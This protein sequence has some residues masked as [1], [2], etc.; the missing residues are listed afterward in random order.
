M[1]AL[2][3][4]QDELIAVTESNQPT[5]L[6]SVESRQTVMIIALHN[7]AV[8]YEYLK[9]FQSALL[10]YQKARD[11]AMKMLGEAH[12]FSEKMD[13]VLEESAMKIKGILE[14]QNKRVSKIGSVG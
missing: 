3:L 1:K 6:P 11:F 5:G 10:T 9:Q 4:I 14:R 12:P 7:I 13:T 2:V 8:E